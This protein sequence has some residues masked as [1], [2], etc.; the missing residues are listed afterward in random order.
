MNE[1]VPEDLVILGRISGLYGVRGWVKIFSYTDPRENILN[2]K[3]WY[4][5]RGSHWQKIKLNEGKRHGKGVVARLDDC[6]DRDIAAAWM[7]SEIA[8]HRDQLP[9]TATDEYY[10]RDLIGLQVTTLDGF[11]L[12]VV[13]N[14]LATG[15]NDVL[16]IKGDK[17]YLVPFVQG[18]F[19]IE[20]DLAVGSMIVDWD[21]DF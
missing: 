1:I 10:W 6:Q 12:G 2:Y 21:P 7:D 18:Q 13:D 3:P 4:I 16:V 19:V 5:R 8:I 20:I 17:E 14:L 15:A 9:K 11:S